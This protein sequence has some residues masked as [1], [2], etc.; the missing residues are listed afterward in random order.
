MSVREYCPC[1]AEAVCGVK[2]HISIHIGEY[3]A[4][5]EPTVVNTV[6][7]SCVAVC[8]FDPESRIG[9]VNHILLPGKADMGHFD[10]SARYGINAMELLI[11]R[12]LGIGADRSRLVAKVFGGAH[13]IPAISPENGTGEKNVAFVMAFLEKEKICVLSKDV[14]GSDS[15]R[16]Y[17]HTDTGHVFLKRV[18]PA[19]QM[20]IRQKEALKIRRV[21]K[22]VHRPGEVTLWE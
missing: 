4:S 19:L 6:L 18:A 21:R 20:R 9:G 7:G 11:N 3:H 10:V 16:I 14:G 13:V 12:M 1:G 17:F 5:R 15:R 8:L 22:E 2:P